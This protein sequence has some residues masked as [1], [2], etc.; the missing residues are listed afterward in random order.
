MHQILKTSKYIWGT[1]VLIL[2]S[3]HNYWGGGE[4][5]APPLATALTFVLYFLNLHLRANWD[6]QTI[7][8]PCHVRPTSGVIKEICEV[9]YKEKE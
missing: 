1:R 7:T 5:P 3:L 4:G 8:Q 2:F 6:T 9:Y